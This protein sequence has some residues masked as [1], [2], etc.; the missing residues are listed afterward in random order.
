MATTIPAAELAPGDVIGLGGAQYRVHEMR[1][2]GLL[3]LAWIP[4][5]GAWVTFPPDHPVALV[6]RGT[7][8]KPLRAVTGTAGGVDLPE[9]GCPS[10][11]RSE[12]VTT[13]SMDPAPGAAPTGPVTARRW[14]DECGGPLLGRRDRR[15]CSGACR[16]AAH[17]R[18]RALLGAPRAASVTLAKAA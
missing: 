8:Q 1:R 6:R 12:P 3:V 4:R 9:G 16:V 15:F 18:G 5:F 7:A 10:E 11:R 2:D 17:R 14:C 13:A